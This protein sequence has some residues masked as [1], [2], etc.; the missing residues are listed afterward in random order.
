MNESQLIARLGEFL[1]MIQDR[2]I[3]EEMVALLLRESRITEGFEQR[4]LLNSHFRQFG[5]AEKLPMVDGGVAFEVAEDGSCPYRA[6]FDP[7]TPGALRSFEFWC[8]GC[9]AEDKNCGVCGGSGWGVL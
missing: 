8:F 1:S 5:A 7:E 6:V 4:Y 9:F 3:D 2:T